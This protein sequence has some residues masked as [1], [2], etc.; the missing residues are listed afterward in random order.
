MKARE[1]EEK[2]LEKAIERE[3]K[4]TS[5]KRKPKSQDQ[6]DDHLFSENGSEILGKEKRELIITI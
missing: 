2:R 6:D 1:R 5:T 4:K 3:N